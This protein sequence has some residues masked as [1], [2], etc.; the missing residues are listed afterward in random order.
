MINGSRGSANLPRSISRYVSGNQSHQHGGNFIRLR[1]QSVT[2]ADRG[3]PVEHWADSILAQSTI[4][5]QWR[6][7]RVG[8]SPSR[9]S[10]DGSQNCGIEAPLSGHFS[11]ALSATDISGLGSGVVFLQLVFLGFA[12][13]HIEHISFAYVLRDLGVQE[14]WV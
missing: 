8:P 10:R 14:Q 1:P 5:S 9:T 11:R 6:T 7:S 2:V 13:I 12:I 3:Q 4:P